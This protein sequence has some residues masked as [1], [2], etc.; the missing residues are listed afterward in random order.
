MSDQY[1]HDVRLAGMGGQGVVLAGLILGTAAVFD[2]LYAT[3]S[4]SYGAQAR[5]S[6]CQAEV[7][8]A[9]EPI[10]Y[11]HV[12][13][14]DLLVAM[15]QEGYE[16][17][18]NRLS[19]GGLLLYDSGLVAT[20]ET[21]NRKGFEVAA[22]AAGQLKNSQVANLIWVGVIASVTGWIHL[23]AINEAVKQRVPARFLEL[24]LRALE[25]GLELGRE[26][27]NDAEEHDA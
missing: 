9:P 15:S 27:V 24:N 5:G 13:N 16:S 8:I 11:P 17:A 22:T 1:V 2:G 14:A 26:A 7:R 18:E 23:D 25:K 10:D 6:V 3:G 20:F 12:D 4:N 21:E 19:D